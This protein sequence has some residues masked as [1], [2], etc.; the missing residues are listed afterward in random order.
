MASAFWCAADLR[1]QLENYLLRRSVDDRFLGFA[2]VGGTGGAWELKSTRANRYTSPAIRF[3]ES[4]L[5]TSK[6]RL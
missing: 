1:G 3:R 2:E 5:S 4:A 6:A